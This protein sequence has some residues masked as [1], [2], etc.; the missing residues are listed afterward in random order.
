[1]KYLIIFILLFIGLTFSACNK[2]NRSPV[3]KTTYQI[4][5]TANVPTFDFEN[6]YKHVQMQVSFGPRNPGSTGHQ[7]ALDY[8]TSEL[9]K[10]TNEV[11]LQNFTYPGYDNSNLNL[12]NVVAKF[13]PNAKKRIFISA[14]WDSRPWADQDIDSTKRNLPI[15]G[16]NDGASGVGIL[17]EIARILKNNNISYGVDLILFDGED[18]G[19]QHDLMNYCLGSKYFASQ[20]Q[21]DYNPEFG[22]LLDLVGDKEA[23]FPKEGNSVLFA[24]EIVDLLWDVAFNLQAS[25]FSNKESQPIYDDHIPLN[26]AGIKTIDIVDVDLIGA[27]S[28]NPR[29]NYW[30][31]H[32]DNMDNISKETLKQVGSV[33]IK[34][35]Y[36]LQI[37]VTTS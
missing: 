34:F 37:S 26:E 20:K 14:H 21:D 15:P 3:Q 4:S 23:V 9:K 36:S 22:I 6:A 30:H 11:S 24:P 33:L 29:R 12:T 18:Y 2:D 5:N 31:T 13:N 17:L 10:Y 28:P 1:M 32:N 7:K 8:F 27:D 35:I 19:H 25:S 16:A